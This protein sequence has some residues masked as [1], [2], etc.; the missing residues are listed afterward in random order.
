MFP[1][2]Q[3]KGRTAIKGLSRVGGGNHCSLSG[4]RIHLVSLMAMWQFWESPPPWGAR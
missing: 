2:Q 3:E 1:E 4:N